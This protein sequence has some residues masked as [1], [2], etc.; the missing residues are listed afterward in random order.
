ML[1]SNLPNPLKEDVQL[2][3]FRLYKESG[4]IRYRD[5]LIEHNKR[6]IQSV[7]NEKYYMHDED[8]MFALGLE[9]LFR[10]VEKFDLS[11]GVKFSTYAVTCILNEINRYL[12]YNSCAKRSANIIS[13]DDAVYTNPD[14]Q[15]QVFYDDILSREEDNPENIYFKSYFYNILEEFFS[16]I[17]VRDKIMF[18]MYYGLNEYDEMLQ[19]EIALIMGVERQTVSLK[20]KITLKKLRKFLS[21]KGY[22]NGEQVYSRKL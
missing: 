20:N 10:A 7:L 4:D 21:S 8:E 22:T 11:K 12:N 6:L 16:S 13:L 3:Y 9:A 14:K 18:Q 15:N 17:A 2:E 19:R 1:K 5:L